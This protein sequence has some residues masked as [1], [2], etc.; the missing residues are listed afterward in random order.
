MTFT[1]LRP[2]HVLALVASLALLLAMSIDWYTTKVGEQL[3]DE[4]EQIAPELDRRSGEPKL[5]ELDRGAAEK[6]EKN[7][8]QA[9]AFVDR[10]I[11][12]GCLAA[13]A[14]AIAAAFL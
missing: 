6:E 8:W 14:L 12:I 2:G 3:R 1:R 11:L 9:N 7:A 10:A 4:Q 13:V 5:S